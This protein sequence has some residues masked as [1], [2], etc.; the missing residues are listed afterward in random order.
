MRKAAALRDAEV[1]ATTPP[2]SGAVVTPQVPT[3]P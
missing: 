3:A 2:A 1:N